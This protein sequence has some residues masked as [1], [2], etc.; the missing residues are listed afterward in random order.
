M[1]VITIIYWFVSL[2]QHLLSAYPESSTDIFQIGIHDSIQDIS[3]LSVMTV[4][5]RL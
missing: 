5:D 4:M 3:V 2:C 1:R